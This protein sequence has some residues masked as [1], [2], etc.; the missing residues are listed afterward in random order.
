M[1][2]SRRVTVA[3]LVG[4][5]VVCAALFAATYVLA[6]HT[7]RGR[8][9]DGASLRGASQ[10]RSR[11]T[12][13]VEGLLDA[14]SATSLVVAIVIIAMIALLRLRRDLALAAVV[15][16]VG[17]TVTAQVLKRYLL[18]RPDLGI[19]ET[20]PAT[21]NSL[22]SGHATVALSVVVALVL[23]LPVRLRPA[24]AGAG[25]VYAALTAFATL[26]AGWHRPSDGVAAFLLVGAWAAAAQAGVILH[27]SGAAKADSGAPP[28]EAR[29]AHRRTAQRL[30][31]AAAY[32]I[33]FGSL[34]VVI[35]V[36]TRLDPYGTAAQVCAYLA[37]GGLLGGTAAAVVAT[38]VV[39]LAEV[40]VADDGASPVDR[41]PSAGG[42]TERSAARLGSRDGG[43][44]TPGGGTRGRE[45]FG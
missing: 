3:W 38:I 43:L 40:P 32:L 4:V 36:L 20:T 45:E 31:V 14:V 2:A 7:T 10:S 12:S 21:L 37:A 27:N 5:C 23:V 11:V 18:T 26:S 44:P 9:L 30:G 28:P 22:P 29:A 16:I 19:H 25:V 15:V 6:V 41:R 8:V 42:T 34:L 39:T 24:A 13:A 33:A 17:S 1:V 35:V